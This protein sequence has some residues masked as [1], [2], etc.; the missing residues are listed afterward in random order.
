MAVRVTTVSSP[1]ACE[2]SSPQL[3]PAGLLVTVPAPEV[4]TVNVNVF[5]KVAVTV[6]AA[7]I[8]T[9]QFPTPEQPAPLQPEKIALAPGV[10]VRVTTVPMS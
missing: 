9:T 7:L 10:A 5:V 4:E 2:Q 3:M 8:V 1:Y 6:R